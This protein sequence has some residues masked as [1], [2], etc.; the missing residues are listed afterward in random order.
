MTPSSSSTAA[1]SMAGQTRE[2]QLVNRLLDQAASDTTGRK[3]EEL[4][5]R[6]I[7]F[8]T[9][10]QRVGNVHTTGAAITGTRGD[11]GRD[12]EYQTTGCGRQTVRIDCKI[13]E[14]VT[15]FLG[16]LDGVPG[17]VTGM[18]VTYPGGYTP[19]AIAE[20][21]KRPGAR[22]VDVIL[23]TGD[24]LKVELLLAPVGELHLGPVGEADEEGD[25][26]GVT[27][28]A[29]WTH[30]RS[31]DT[32]SALAGHTR[33]ARAGHTRGARARWTHARRARSLDTRAARALA[34]HTRGMCAERT[35]VP[36]ESRHMKTV[37]CSQ[38]WP[39]CFEAG[40]T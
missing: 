8:K 23:I 3:L 6:W 27:E 7:S 34:G 12:L 30:A 17:N 5:E 31:A 15:Y 14:S 39:R 1:L 38:L 4:T 19:D 22:H 26:D 24:H 13:L 35:A 32:R 9:N 28:R 40:L 36:V 33:A 11:G 2:Q 10:G 29:G 16:R 20:V 25:A 37:C 21:E 18:L